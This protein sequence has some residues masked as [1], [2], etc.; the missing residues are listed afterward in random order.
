LKTSSMRKWS[1]FSHMEFK[2]LFTS[3]ISTDLILWNDDMSW[4]HILIWSAWSNYEKNIILVYLYKVHHFKKLIFASSWL[5]LRL[6]S[7]VLCI[8]QT[9]N[10]ELSLAL[11]FLWFCVSWHHLFQYWL[12]DTLM[13]PSCI[14]YCCLA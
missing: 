8:E 12:L 3:F 9:T 6:Y 13:I 7:H 4:C 1:S 5:V 11:G 2:L 10:K 14:W